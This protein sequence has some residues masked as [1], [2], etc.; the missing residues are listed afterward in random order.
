MKRK[1]DSAKGSAIIEFAFVLP[2]LLILFFGIIEF[3][4]ALYDKAILTNASREAARAGVMYIGPATRL[5]DDQVRALALANCQDNMITFQDDAA[6]TVTITRTT[7]PDFTQQLLTVRLDYNYTGLGLGTL[8]TAMS[9]P[10]E[11]SAS[12][13]MKNE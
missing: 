12:T 13:T 7:H 11:I 4:V 2:V 9:G 5:T 10:I 6:P 1:H 8:L 3:S